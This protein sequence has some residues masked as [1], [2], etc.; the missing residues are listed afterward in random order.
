MSGICSQKTVGST[1]YNYPTQ[2]G[3]VVRLVDSTGATIANYT[4]DNC[5]NPLS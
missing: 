1:I 5:G 3:Q 4:Y 2:N